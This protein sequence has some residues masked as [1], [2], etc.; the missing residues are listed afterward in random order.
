LKS[1]LKVWFGA[2]LLLAIVSGALEAA[3][4]QK[5]K[6]TARPIS[7]RSMENVLIDGS[8]EAGAAAWTFTGAVRENKVA[9]KDGSWYARIDLVRDP[10]GGQYQ[11][12]GWV[13]QTIATVAGKTYPV[14]FWYSKD[15][16]P[17]IFDSVLKVQID[18]GSGT[19]STI[20]TV[21]AANQNA[22]V[23]YLE[24]GAFT[25]TGATARIRF[26]VEG[27]Q[28]SFWRVDL[29]SV[30]APPTT[31]YE[32]I[33]QIKTGLLGK[34]RTINVASGFQTTAGTVEER[35]IRIDGYPAYP[36]YVLRPAGGESVEDEGPFRHVRR[37]AYWDVFAFVQTDDDAPDAIHAAVRDITKAV[38][39]DQTLGGIGSLSDVRGRAVKVESW[40]PWEV[41]PEVQKGFQAVSVRVRTIYV[42]E[43]GEI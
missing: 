43:Q 31:E 22:G 15:G 39:T 41:A 1:K 42:T 34:L 33:E 38:E 28:S 2:V 23:W 35:R 26:Q 12:G 37:V 40:D 24:T 32:L 19:F 6:A 13:Q 30:E 20:A 29:V 10:K 7:R 5:Q 16:Y 36:A 14:A 11:I 3:T 25:A 8:F 18:A 17:I 27:E 21:G 4:V 9:A